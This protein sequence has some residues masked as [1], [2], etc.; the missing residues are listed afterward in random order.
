MRD[1]GGGG[2]D[3]MGRLVEEDDGG[4]GREGLVTDESET[5]VQ[6]Y[7]LEQHY[8]PPGTLSDNTHPD[9]HHHCS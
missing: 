7:I 4:G 1:A 8:G 5:E 6:C 2:D 3:E 9:S